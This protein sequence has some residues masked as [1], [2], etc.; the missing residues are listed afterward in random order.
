[1]ADR[2]ANPGWKLY[3]YAM[4][5]FY[6]AVF[7]S[8]GWR[9]SHGSH[10]RWPLELP[11]ARLLEIMPQM[12]TDIVL[13]R[14]RAGGNGPGRR[15]VIDTKFTSIVTGGWQREQSLR[16]GNIYQMYAYL[17]SQES[18][19]DPLSDN[20]AGVLLYPSLGEDYDESAIVQG[21][22]IR[23]AT[24]DLA[25]DTPTIRRQLLRVVE[26]EPPGRAS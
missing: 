5:G 7:S 8:Q 17:R 21:H 20:S 24:V 22:P 1:M 9:V 16:S 15:I 4:A 14:P 6:R 19:G 23:F 12:V 3:E 18:A 2:D 13:E 11:T 10:I 26:E 25:A